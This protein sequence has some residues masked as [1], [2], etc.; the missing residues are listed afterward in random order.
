MSRCQLMSERWSDRVFL[1]VL[2]SAAVLIPIAGSHMYFYSDEWEMLSDRS[3][4]TV[5]GWL[6]PHNNVHWIPGPVVLFRLLYNM[7]GVDHYWAYQLPGLSMHLLAAWMLRQIM[8]DARVDPWIAT[9]GAS[10]FALYGAGAGNMLWA[11]QV[12]FITSLTMG[13]VHLRLAMRPEP[14]TRTDLLGVAAGATSILFGSI[15]V[16]MVIVVGIATL[17]RRG[18]RAS[19]LHTGPLAFLYFVWWLLFAAGEV[20]NADY[21]NPSLWA[22][23]LWHGFSETFGT[24]V[25]WA[26]LGLALAL[27]TTAGWVLLAA[28]IRRGEDRWSPY[29]P[30][31]ALAVGAIV[32]QF[33]AALGRVAQ[34]LGG[35]I[36]LGPE[37]ARSSRYIYLVAALTIPLIAVGLTALLGRW[38]HVSL[39]V[40]GMFALGLFT[41]VGWLLSQEKVP[42]L[43][44][45]RQTPTRQLVSD[46]AYS[47]LIDA[48]P[49]DSEVRIPFARLRSGWLS[50]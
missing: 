6:E 33:I 43:T 14:T 13:L 30:P 41:N 16:A 48:V 2:G 3:L 20:E 21:G 47:P 15:G 9:A 26:P 50:D 38:P 35:F 44:P 8:L 1:V 46:V 36:V 40:A 39:L 25:G 11:F 45:A 12:G 28:Q 4:S 27:A 18:W 37:G 5:A 49:P 10:L 32:M 23:W 19:L 29:V 24:M 42:A 17:A 34:P 7:I 22:R 31:M